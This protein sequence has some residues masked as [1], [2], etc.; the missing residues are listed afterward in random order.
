[1]HCVMK[2]GDAVFKSA[3]VYNANMLCGSGFQCERCG[4][5]VRRKGEERRGSVGFSVISAVLMQGGEERIGEERRGGEAWVTVL[6]H[7]QD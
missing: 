4:A 6:R 7:K 3:Q 2:T 5:D 1:M